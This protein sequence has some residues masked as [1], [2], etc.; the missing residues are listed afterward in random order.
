M[1]TAPGGE[2]P[3]PRWGKPVLG[4]PPTTGVVTVAWAG[5][6]LLA[7][8]RGPAAALARAVP[9]AHAGAGR[10]CR[11]RG[12][13]WWRGPARAQA[14][15]SPARLRL[16]RT[17]LAAVQ[18]VVVALA[19]PRLGP[20]EGGVAGLGLAGRPLPS[21]GAVLPSPGR[22][23]HGRATPLALR[24][25]LPP[26]FPARGRWPLGAARGWPRAVRVAPW[27]QGGPDCSVRGRGR[28][29]G[30][31]ARGDASGRAP[32]T[33]GRRG[34]GPRRARGR[35]AA[36]TPAAA[37]G[38]RPR[39]GAPR[40]AARP[41]PAASAR[42]HAAAPQRGSPA[43]GLPLGLGHHRVDGRAGGGRGGGAAG[44]R[45]AVPGW[46]SSWG[47]PR[48]GRPR[49]DRGDG[50]TPERRRLRG[51]DGAEAPRPACAW[52]AQEPAA[53]SPL[54]RH[55]P[56][57]LVRVRPTAGHRPWRRWERLAGPARGESGAADAH[58]SSPT[59]VRDCLPISPRGG[60]L[61]QRWPFP[62][63]TPP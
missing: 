11:R 21:G 32:R 43:L 23:G 33:A 61:T 24:P 20:W 44:T 57:P 29:W 22:Q 45:R 9:A 6:C 4:R 63:A 50:R 48:R 7:A 38:D 28:A 37:P 47:G 60:G 18:P 52:G 59:C 30:T 31:G 17:R 12:R 58:G 8:P 35:G 53:A 25:P 5:R 34:V 42:A 3:V 1:T 62:R 46:A 16:A 19:T 49:A 2:R 15:S 39:A 13:R 10:A 14:T 41:A 27:R 26:A 55:R 56:D 54:D 51:L 40:P 36:A